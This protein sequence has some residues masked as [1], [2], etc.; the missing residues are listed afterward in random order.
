MYKRERGFCF[1]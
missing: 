1:V